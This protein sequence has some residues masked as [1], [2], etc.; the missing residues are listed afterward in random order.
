LLRLYA[1]RGSKVLRF[2]S[3]VLHGQSRAVVEPEHV[4]ELWSVDAVP[5]AP[6]RRDK[7][8]EITPSA[9]GG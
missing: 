8:V 6:G 1:G 3:V 4:A 7:Y 2:A 5:W 9:I